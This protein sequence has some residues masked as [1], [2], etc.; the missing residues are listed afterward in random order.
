MN[1]FADQFFDSRLDEPLNGSKR[2]GV[3]RMLFLP[4]VKI[5]SVVGDRQCVARHAATRVDQRNRPG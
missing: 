4:A 1:R 2:F 3:G 5:R